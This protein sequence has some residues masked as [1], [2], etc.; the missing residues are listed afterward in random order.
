V[1]PAIYYRIEES[2]ADPKSEAVVKDYLVVITWVDDVRYFGTEKF[3]KEYEES[4]KK[5]CK[6]TM[7]GDSDEFLS[8]EIKQ[9]LGNKTVELTQTKYWEKSGRKIRRV[10]S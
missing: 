4:V 1:D 3:V 10:P 5:N 6:C 2:A 8:I 7:E 9:D